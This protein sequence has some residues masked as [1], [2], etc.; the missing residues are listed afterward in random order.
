MDGEDFEDLGERLFGDLGGELEDGALAL[1]L[2]GSFD[3]VFPVPDVLV[4]DF[5]FEDGFFLG[6]FLPHA[7]ISLRNP[8]TI[9]SY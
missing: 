9:D 8:I 2:D 7:S 6:K 5:P 4:D 3:G 1:F